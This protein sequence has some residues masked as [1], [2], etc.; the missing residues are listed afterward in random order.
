MYPLK[1]FLSEL[2]EEEYFNFLYIYLFWGQDWG[3]HSFPSMLLKVRAQ[4]VGVISP[5]TM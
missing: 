4:L 2:Y 5:H 3:L 1:I